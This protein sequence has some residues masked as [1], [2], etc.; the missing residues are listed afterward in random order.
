M[1]SVDQSA[2][3]YLRSTSSSSS[4]SSAPAASGQQLPPITGMSVTVRAP[5]ADALSATE[6]GPSSAP[7]EGHFWSRYF[8]PW[9]GIPE[10]PVNGSS[11]TILGPYWAGELGLL[12][13]AEEGDMEVVGGSGIEH[14]APLSMAAGVEGRGSDAGSSSALTPPVARLRASLR[15]IQQSARG[16][17]LDITVEEARPV[18][19][20]D[21]VASGQCLTIGERRYGPV[22]RAASS[23]ALE[24]E[25]VTV[26]RGALHACS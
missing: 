9:N 25:C 15:G 18:L 21:A 14:G 10:D 7:A 17:V 23:V 5:A 11:H 12:R 1:H 16:G 13:E 2:L 24:G 6:E 4:S 8:S 19:A 22:L 3:S 20:G 26:Y